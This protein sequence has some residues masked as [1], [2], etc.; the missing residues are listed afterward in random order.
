LVAGN[1]V[2]LSVSFP[3]AATLIAILWSSTNAWPSNQNRD[4]DVCSAVF[5]KYPIRIS[6]DLQFFLFEVLF[7]SP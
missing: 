3:S 7:S 5:E 1:E 6:E 2:A 4:R